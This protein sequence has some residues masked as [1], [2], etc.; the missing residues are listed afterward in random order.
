MSDNE[1]FQ[2]SVMGICPLCNKTEIS[3]RL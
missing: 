1:E 2:L 3:H